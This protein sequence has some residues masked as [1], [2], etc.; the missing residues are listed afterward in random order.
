MLPVFDAER[1]HRHH[2]ACH[3]RRAVTAARY[4]TRAVLGPECVDNLRPS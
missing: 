2:R 4:L 1:F 3:D